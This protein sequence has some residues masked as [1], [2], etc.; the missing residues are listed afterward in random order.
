MGEA[1]FDL[2]NTRG[3]GIWEGEVKWFWYGV[4]DYGYVWGC[5]GDGREGAGFTCVELRFQERKRG[6]HICQTAL[7][8]EEKK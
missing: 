6:L 8:G 5:E 7:F 4:R 2:V 1:H 3:R